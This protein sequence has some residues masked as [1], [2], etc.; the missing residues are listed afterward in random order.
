[1]GLYIVEMTKSVIVNAKNK[2]KARK[3]ASEM[4]DRN[5]GNREV[6]VNKL[7]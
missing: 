6:T 2:K 1:M 7:Y 5:M 4:F 3:K